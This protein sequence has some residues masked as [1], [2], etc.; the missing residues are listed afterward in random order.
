MCCTWPGLVYAEVMTLK[1]LAGEDI[2]E[3]LASALS[4]VDISAVLSS[5]IVMA[6]LAYPLYRLSE[7]LMKDKD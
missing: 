2:P 3:R 1:R 5:L 7:Y 6:I 4:S